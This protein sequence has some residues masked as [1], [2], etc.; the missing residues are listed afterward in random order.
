MPCDVREL[1]TVKLFELLEVKTNKT[2]EPIAL[3]EF[4]KK[5]HHHHHH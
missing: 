1:A 2:E 4:E 5:V 3:E